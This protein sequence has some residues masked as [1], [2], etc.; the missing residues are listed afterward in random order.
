MHSNIQVTI[1]SATS[2]PGFIRR[3]F[4][5]PETSMVLKNFIRSI[6]LFRFTKH[7]GQ[8]FGVRLTLCMSTAADVRK[9]CIVA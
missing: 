4:N 5:Q 6:E 2:A 3:D 7:D 1:T 8:L 9:P